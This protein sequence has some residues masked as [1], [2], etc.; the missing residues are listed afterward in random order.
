MSAL[1]ISNYYGRGENTGMELYSV[2]YAWPYNR[3]ID[4]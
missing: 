3:G 4:I 2:R 1:W